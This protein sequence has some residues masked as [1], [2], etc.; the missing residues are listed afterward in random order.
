V[1]AVKLLTKDEVAAYMQALGYERADE[2]IS[3]HSCWRSPCGLHL[4]VPEIPPD[5][6]TAEY[7]LV[8]RIAEIDAEARRRAN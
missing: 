7:W 6:V 1:I 8:D 5:G 3:G 4:F 2:T